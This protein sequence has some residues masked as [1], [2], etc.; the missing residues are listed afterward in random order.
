M[1]EL[2]ITSRMMLIALTPALLVTC[3]LS[4]YFVTKRVKSIEA[5]EVQ[6]AQT[7]AE[8][9]ALASEFAL[10]TQNSDLL[11]DVAKPALQIQS[12][13]DIRFL[14]SQDAVV[15]EEQSIVQKHYPVGTLGQLIRPW[16]SDLPLTSIVEKTVF[17]TDLSQYDDPY[18]A[19]ADTLLKGNNEPKQTIGKVQLTVDLSAAYKQQLKTIR[20][21]L[22]M[23]AL[24]MMLAT[25]AAYRL[26]RSVSQPIREL[27]GAVKQ[28]AMNN[29][30]KNVPVEIGGELG[31]LS[32]GVS[33]LSDELQSFHARLS[34]S[35]RIATV[36]LQN[37]LSVLERRNQELDD[38]RTAAEQ[39]SAFKSDF[40][41]NMSHE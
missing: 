29:Y 21:A 28:L 8:G 40:L 27:T 33:H 34:E 37:T 13:A 7:L 6:K 35:T 30:V 11:T 19:T 25:P 10:A 4:L 5:S 38:S 36:D 17:R 18:F 9:L 16:I 31:E 20:Q 15:I 2:S 32:L 41:A 14:N 23:A 26:A 3:L 12:I 24:I 1:R 39:A 22:F